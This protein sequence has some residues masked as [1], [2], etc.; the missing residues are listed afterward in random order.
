MLSALSDR[1]TR[2]LTMTDAIALRPRAAGGWWRGPPSTGLDSGRVPTTFN[3]LQ[4][5]FKFPAGEVFSVIHRFV[6]SSLVST[7]P[8]PLQT[9]GHLQTL[10]T[11]CANLSRG[12]VSRV[13]NQQRRLCCGR[14][15]TLD[16]ARRYWQSIPMATDSDDA[17]PQGPHEERAPPR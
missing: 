10:S 4:E 11:K 8:N 14:K 12:M 7:A 13:P 2:G 3:R 6:E 16:V 17:S 9:G 15:S 5:P 1:S